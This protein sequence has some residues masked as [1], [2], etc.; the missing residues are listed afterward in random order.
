VEDE[1]DSSYNESFTPNANDDEPEG[2]FDTM[3]AKSNDNQDVFPTGEDGP[4]S[5]NSGTADDSSDDEDE[6]KQA[7]KRE[8]GRRRRGRKD[9]AKLIEETKIMEEPPTKKQ[10]IVIKPEKENSTVSETKERYCLGR[11]P[12]T[13]FTVGQKYPGR[14]VYIKDFGVF[15]DIGCHSDAFCHVS[16]LR[17]DFVANPHELFH[18]GDLVDA[19]VVEIDRRHKRITVSL[20]SDERAADE[21]ASVESR[22]ERK[23]LRKLKEAKKKNPIH[24]TKKTE[25]S[26]VHRMVGDK[27]GEKLQDTISSSPRKNIKP[28]RVE[29]PKDSSD[30]AELKRQRKL[31]RRA[32]RRESEG[33]EES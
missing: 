20:Q 31:A 2:Q 8:R 1:E 27:E 6:E 29:G 13:D 4:S 9:T 19:R 26:I 7:L 22:A 18:E 30:P 23:K 14:V 11:K 25:S 33:I 10:K 32:A 28:V 16:R 15:F 17:D 5:G 12:V 3:E 24:K 21:R